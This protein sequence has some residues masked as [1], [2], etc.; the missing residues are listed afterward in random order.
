MLK[1]L[2]NME[3]VFG[4]RKKTIS[5]KD[6]PEDE[7]IFNYLDS[8]RGMS[9]YIK[10][11]VD[12]DMKKNGCDDDENKKNTNINKKSERISNNNNSMEIVI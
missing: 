9:A 10:D 1:D 4:M 6:N 2:I 11:L 5:F 3:G 12:A 7:R 8:K